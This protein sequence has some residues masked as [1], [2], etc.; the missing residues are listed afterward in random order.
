M[1]DHQI[2]H[3]E[4]P[5]AVV[6]VGLYV[7]KVRPVRDQNRLDARSH[8]LNAFLADD[9]GVDSG[10]MI[11]QYTSAGI[12]IYQ[13]T[14]FKYANK[15]IE[16]IT[17]YTREEILGM[18]FWDLVTPEFQDLV[19][20]RG[21]AVVFISHNLPQVLEV[22]DRIEVLRLGRRVMRFTRSDATIDGIVGA[23][24][25]SLQAPEGNGS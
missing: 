10:H 15:V 4:V 11:A 18:N 8:G 24:T 5:F 21:L 9:P 6:G 14:K 12:V 20:D 19:R 25:G 23:M 22:A 13:G 17:G 1:G 3:V 16:T 7:E 2:H